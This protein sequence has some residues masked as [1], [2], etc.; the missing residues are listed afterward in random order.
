VTPY[1]PWRPDVGGPDSGVAQTA[2]GVLPQS[3]GQ[4]IGYG[5]MNAQVTPSGAVSLGSDPR[6][7]ITIQ[8]QDGAWQDYAATASKIRLLDSTYDWDD[9]ETGRSV[10]SGDDVSFALFG[11]Y[12]LNA[13]TTDGFKAY[14]YESG[15]TNDA[16]TGNG[17]PTAVRSLCVCNNVVF[18]LDCDG[19]NRRMESSAQGSHTEWRTGGA[20]GKTFEDGGALIGMRD[21]R[22]GL[23]V[24]FQENAI[25]L[26]QFGAA[27]EGAL[28]TV[29]KVADGLGAASDRA[30]AA[31]NGRAWFVANGGGLYEYAAGGDPVPIGD[32]K[33]NNWLAGQVAAA[34]LGTIQVSVDPS[35]K[36]TWFRLSASLMLGYHWTL[37]EF[38][39][40]TVSTSALLRLATPAVLID[41]LVG[42]VDDQTATIDSLDFQG[43]A[44][45]FGS[46][47]SDGKINRFTGTPLAA[48]LRSCVLSAGGSKRFLQAT[49]QSDDATSTLSIGTT[50]SLAVAPSYS[51]PAQRNEDGNVMLDDR[52]RYYVFR[53]QHAAGATWTYCN[54]VDG[55]VANPD[56]P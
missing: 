49:P 31:Y 51:T 1:G 12:L 15:G 3:A 35:R 45:T 30:I 44:P 37:R 55:V 27:P 41:D 38:V 20:D 52:G 43:G 11:P 34:D 19:N 26:V 16:V 53:E 5:P 24:V 36:M 10:T 21:L 6:G 22:N 8:R 56:A 7:L 33:V 54:G 4:G 32:Q 50:D 39:T 25:R 29:T 47:G 13:D 2:D 17:A 48:D 46:L 42:L 18:A 40:A 14:N 23:G 9:I 28:Y